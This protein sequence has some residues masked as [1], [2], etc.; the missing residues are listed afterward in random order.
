MADVNHVHSE[1]NDP[2]HWIASG[3]CYERLALQAAAFD[4]RTAFTNQPV[5]VSRLR[6]QFA[7]YLGI[8]NRRPD[9]V[10]RIGHAPLGPKS[11][12]RRTAEVVVSGRSVPAVDHRA[13]AAAANPSAA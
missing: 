3:R 2:Q 13:V 11:L 7:Q 8:G 9:L 12:R 6:P 1:K 10:I 4:L 5:E